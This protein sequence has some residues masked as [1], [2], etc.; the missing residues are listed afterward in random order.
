MALSLFIPPALDTDTN[1]E[2]SVWLTFLPMALLMVLLQTGAEELLFRGYLQQQLAARF[3]TPIIW[4]VLPSVLF[5]LGH[6]NPEQFGAVSWTVVGVTTLVGL[7]AADLTART[8]TIGAAWG[9]HFTNNV[10][11]ILLVSL[12][13][14]LSGLSLYVVPA[15]NVQPE[16]LQLALLRDI[17]VISIIWLA[18]R[19]LVRR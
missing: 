4:M 6:W 3:R 5:G 2:V 11:A 1:L 16:T 8:G 12:E 13:G 15:A 17:A 18:I 14:P 7:F 9:F 10:A 19:Q